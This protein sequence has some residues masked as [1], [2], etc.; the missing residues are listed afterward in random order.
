M[1]VFI[2]TRFA[3]PSLDNTRITVRLGQSVVEL[4]Q[5]WRVFSLSQLRE[6]G[7]GDLPLGKLVRLQP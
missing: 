5:H 2:E 6:V 1:P 3:N 4:F 7:G